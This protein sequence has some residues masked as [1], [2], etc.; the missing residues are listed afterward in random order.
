MKWH[1]VREVPFMNREKRFDIDYLVRIH[2]FLIKSKIVRPVVNDGRALPRLLDDILFNVALGTGDTTTAKIDKFSGFS[3]TSK[4][5]LM[6][7]SSRLMEL[8]KQVFK[9]S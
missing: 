4:A 7:R 8:K 5:A 9:D 2:K 1:G 6:I 3:S